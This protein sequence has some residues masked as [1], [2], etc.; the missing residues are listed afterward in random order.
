VF[1]G[2]IEIDTTF[3]EKR[4]GDYLPKGKAKVL[5]AALYFWQN[6][7]VGHY[8]VTT[9][10]NLYNPNRK[11]PAYPLSEASKKRKR[12]RLTQNNVERQLSGLIEAA[13]GRMRA[14]RRQRLLDISP[15]SV[16]LNHN[17][18]TIFPPT[19][20]TII[21]THL[22]LDKVIIANFVKDDGMAVQVKVEPGDTFKCMIPE[23]S[24]FGIAYF[25]APRTH[26]RVFLQCGDHIIP[27]EK[28]FYW[29]SGE[30]CFFFSSFF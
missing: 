5:E 27:G 4:P 29:H 24:H 25:V 21:G 17:T 7:R 1:E 20:L 11:P 10:F 9:E 23:P 13:Q 30:D 6:S 12:P 3:R 8:T 14:E 19:K 2:Y 15:I 26:A 22:P 18:Q 16:T 28:D